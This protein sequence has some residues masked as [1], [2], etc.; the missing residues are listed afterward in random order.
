MSAKDCLY[1]VGD[2]IDNF[3]IVKNG[4]LAKKV[5]VNIEK[6][7]RWPIESKIWLQNIVATR[8]EI[9]IKFEP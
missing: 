7:N 2:P 3:Y 4:I 1:K 5:V 6:S 9:T 8:Q